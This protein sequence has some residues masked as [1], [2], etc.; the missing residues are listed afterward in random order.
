MKDIKYLVMDVD[1]TLTDGKIYMGQ[2]GEIMKAFNIKDGCGIKETLPKYDIKPVIITARNSDIVVNRCK[3]I[4]IEL[5][6]QG[7]RDKLSKLESILDELSGDKSEV[8]YIGDDAP[9]IPCMEA[10]KNAGGMVLCPSDA[11]PE[12]KAMSD[13]ISGLNAGEGAVRDC[14]NHIIFN[15]NNGDIQSKI[16]HVIEILRKEDFN[17]K[18]PGGYVLPD[19][20][21]YN[22]QD[23]VTK[24]EK[25]C[26]LE[27]HRT[28]ID[29]QYMIEGSEI[30]KT[31]SP[32]CLTSTGRY[33]EEH[34]CEFWQDGIVTTESVLVPGS[35][36]VIMNGQPHKGA[37]KRTGA[38]HVKKVV[39]KI[40]V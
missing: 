27:S 12:I 38:E 28:H 20:T 35:V 25:E 23:Y 37:L 17:D 8:A 22:L 33:D 24:D 26:V 15:K 13:Y 6:Y 36:I 11:L 18:E 31:Y 2:D 34:D 5:V 14:I 9:D 4:G 19:G 16:E 29:V 39:C 10:V 32:D 3:E 21:P 40:E 1:G 7:F 30:L